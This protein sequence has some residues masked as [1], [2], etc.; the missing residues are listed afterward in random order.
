MLPCN[1]S[2]CAPSHTE[3]TCIHDHTALDGGRIALHCIYEKHTGALPDVEP[4]A[5]D[6][7]VPSRRNLFL[8]GAFC[9]KLSVCRPRDGIS[10]EGSNE[11]R[12]HSDFE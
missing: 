1:Q 3:C 9:L 6:E 7:G 2:S 4:D 10:R 8:G 11:A 12:A 5:C